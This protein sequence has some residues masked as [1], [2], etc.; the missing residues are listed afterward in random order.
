M[1]AH[2]KS[3]TINILWYILSDYLAALVASIIFHFSRRLLLSEAIFINHKLFLTNRFWLGAIT[4]PLS[5]LILY[6]MVGSY[7]SLY[8][9]SRLNELTNTFIYSI[10][11]CTI[12]FFLIVIN[13][14]VKDYHYFYKTYFIFLFAHFVLTLSGRIT[15]LN[16]VR[17]QIQQ[18]KVVFNTLLIGSNS[19]ATEI[20]KDSFEG[21]RSSGYQY[22]G[23]VSNDNQHNNGIA[24]YLPQLGAPG[25][26]EKVID[27][28]DIE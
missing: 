14:P 27:H 26:I 10:T 13:D 28:N 6:A 12:I 20:Y 21:L 17:R 11:G 23:Y 16:R 8:K 4:I 18:G 19:V 3:H 25:E 5:W 24:R 22:A 7:T 15:I 9:K 1:P 2:K